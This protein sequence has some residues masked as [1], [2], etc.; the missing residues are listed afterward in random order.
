M[1]D[2]S[3][4]RVERCYGGM[5]DSDEPALDSYIA[6]V[7]AVA[8]VSTATTVRL[9]LALI[10]IIMWWL[11]WAQRISSIA[12]KAARNVECVRASSDAAVASVVSDLMAPGVS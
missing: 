2:T 5:D 4:Q 11:L 7:V 6:E 9:M 8:A 10:V 1:T 3:D 12:D